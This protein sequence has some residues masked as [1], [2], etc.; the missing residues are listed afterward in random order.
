MITPSASDHCYGK[1]RLVTLF[2][3]LLLQLP[4]SHLFFLVHHLDDRDEL[5]KSKRHPRVWLA[6]CSKFTPVGQVHP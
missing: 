1:S 2:F 4:F 6:V 3:F 5:I